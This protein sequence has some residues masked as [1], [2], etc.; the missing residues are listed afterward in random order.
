MAE[1][2]LGRD[3]LREIPVITGGGGVQTESFN[4]GD[5][6]TGGGGGNDAPFIPTTNPIN[7]PAP[8]PFYASYTYRLENNTGNDLEFYY[9]APNSVYKNVT[10]FANS[11]REVC[12]LFNTLTYPSELGVTQL[13]PCDSPTGGTPSTP[14]GT[15]PP[16]P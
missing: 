1:E 6:P 2:G 11:N 16:L 15:R 12:A 14:G 3:S 5:N 4:E 10:V 7:N 9:Q 13:S 8:T